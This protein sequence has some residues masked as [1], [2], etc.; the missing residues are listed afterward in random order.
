N[1]L[2][3]DITL[4]V[5]GNPGF[6]INIQK[7]T[8]AGK[9]G[10]SVCT[11]FSQLCNDTTDTPT[12]TIQQCKPGPTPQLYIRFTNPLDPNAAPLHPNDPNGGYHFKLQLVGNSKYLLDE[13]PVY[14]I[15]TTNIQTPPPP[16]GAGTYMMSGSYEQ[17]VFGA[18]CNF[19][20]VEGEVPG[21]NTCG[22]GDN[23]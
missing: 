20:N 19:Y 3:M 6:T 22:D 13:V 11:S 10:Q 16:P 4:S 8:M 5:V 9:P 23:D 21:M 1:Y 12:N 2:A 7:C 14:I 17:Q 15:P 18:G